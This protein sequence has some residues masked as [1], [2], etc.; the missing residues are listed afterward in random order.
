MITVKSLYRLH[1]YTGV[2]IHIYHKDSDRQ[3][4]ANSEDP[5][6]MTHSP[7]LGLHCLPFIQQLLDKQ[8]SSKMFKF[9][10]EHV[11]DD[12]LAFYIPFNII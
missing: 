3:A 5:Y 1:K 12:D 7:D 6:Q 8:A 4:W 9:L 11:K 2:A 10:D